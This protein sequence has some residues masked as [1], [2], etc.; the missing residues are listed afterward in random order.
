VRREMEARFGHDFGAVRVHVGSIAST[1]ARSLHA[2]AYTIGPHVVFGN[3]N[4]APHSTEGKRLL[5]HELVHVVQQ[6][7]SP[8]NTKTAG[9]SVAQVRG[10]APVG[11]ACA[12]ALD[13]MAAEDRMKAASAAL[14]ALAIR[15]RDRKA[16][17]S[18]ETAVEAMD[19]ITLARRAARVAQDPA[20]IEE[21]DALIARF[22]LITQGTPAAR[23]NAFDPHPAASPE[24]LGHDE[25]A[26]EANTVVTAQRGFDVGVPAGEIGNLRAQIDDV[27][28]KIDRETPT[29]TSDEARKHIGEMQKQV[30]GLRRRLSTATP[31]LKD[32]PTLQSN[33]EELARQLR[34]LPKDAN[35]SKRQALQRRIDV[36]DTRITAVRNVPADP[37][38]PAPLNSLQGG[39]RL[40]HTGQTYVTVQ[41]LDADNK[42]IATVQARNEGAGGPHAEDVVLSRLQALPDRSRLVGAT[43]IVTGD[44]EVCRACN[45]TLNRFATDN[46]LKAVLNNTMV[47][48]TMDSSGNLTGNLG[49]AKTLMSKIAN[50]DAIDK[51]ERANPPGG[52]VTVPVQ[53]QIFPL[54]G[55]D[56]PDVAGGGGGPGGGGGSRPRV[57]YEG[58]GDVVAPIAEHGPSAF[59]TAAADGVAQLVQWGSGKLTEL[60][61]AKQQELANAEINQQIDSIKTMWDVHPERGVLF[62]ITWEVWNHGDAGEIKR[63]VSAV[64][65]Y[66]VDRQSARSTLANVATEVPNPKA[67]IRVDEIWIDPPEPLAVHNLPSPFPK[68]AL[69]TFANEDEVQDVKWRG[70]ATFDDTGFTSLKPV[71]GAEAR[72]FIMQP[73]D[74]IAFM[75]GRDRNT[76]SVPILHRSA[77]GGWTIPVVNLDTLVGYIPFVDRDTAAMVVPAD[78]YT[79]LL[80]KDSNPVKDAGSQLR[81]Y[82]FANVRFVSPNNIRVLK[83]LSESDMPTPNVLANMTEK[84]WAELC[85]ITHG[86]EAQELWARMSARGGTKVS[87]E[88]VKEFMSLLPPDLTMGEVKALSANPEVQKTAMT[89]AQLLDAWR[90][91]IGRLRNHEPTAPDPSADQQQVVA[92]LAK[93]DWAGLTKG[94]YF[95]AEQ[96]EGGPIGKPADTSM[97]CLCYGIE[98]GQ[99]YGV[100]VTL[101]IGAEKDGITPA[102]VKAVRSRAFAPDGKVLSDGSSLLGKTYQLSH[103]KRNATSAA[104]PASGEKSP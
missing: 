11:P 64:P 27:Q 56:A 81:L 34:E 40:G 20:I 55:G 41:I 102:T 60:A 88:F 95:R 12:P 61:D 50:P 93:V 48:P 18:P 33:R 42:L 83:S 89:E 103:V 6:G 98:A 35:A 67:E 28:A 99:R 49:K 25:G 51:L 26:H 90:D 38:A 7:A 104:M 24:P 30:D 36:L 70:R 77:P 52:R 47:A 19:A 13:Y 9:A 91:A 57:T 97:D 58:P 37:S 78:E 72:F 44:Q 68:I 8:P 15:A 59:R 62:T 17:L 63:F 87:P 101:Q 29:A 71:K 54:G 32:L 3:G 1:A 10:R 23:P 45:A 43:M 79:A 14:D 21:A 84:D 86:H 5:A 75:D 96:G 4:Y 92:G 94:I 73:P 39:G 2:A 76:T 100:L 53:T 66:G 65:K 22:D 46:K 74:E 85:I 16:K 80:F 82:E 31:V 69:A